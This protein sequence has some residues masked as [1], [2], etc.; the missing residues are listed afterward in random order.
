[1]GGGN[2]RHYGNHS[3]AVGQH[4]GARHGFVLFQPGNSRVKFLRCPD[5]GNRIARLNLLRPLNR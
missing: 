2:I 3:S 5:A 4:N 1:M